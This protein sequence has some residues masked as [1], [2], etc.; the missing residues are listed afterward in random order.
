M[1][2]LALI[3][4]AIVVSPLINGTNYLLD[5][6]NFDN[7]PFIYRYTF[8]NESRILKNRERNMTKRLKAFPINLLGSL[9][10]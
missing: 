4:A 5:H 2:Q 1:D 9:D 10:L 6:M 3:V 7:H 8:L